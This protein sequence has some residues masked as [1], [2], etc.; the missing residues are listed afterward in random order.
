[1]SND[2]VRPQSE[3][4]VIPLR[5]GARAQRSEPAN[6]AAEA[7]EDYRTIFQSR[8]TSEIG[9]REVIS[10]KAKFGIFGDGKELPQVALARYIEPGDWRHGYYRDQ[11]LMLALRRV[12]VRQLFAQLYADTNIDHDPASGGRQMS[13]HFATRFLDAAGRFTDQLD[14]VNSAP[15]FGPIAFQMAS[16]L[17]LAYA[18]KLYRGNPGLAGV[19]AGFSRG[20]REVVFAS[21]GNASTSEGIF[22]ESI[23][24]AA[25]VQ[26]PMVV[27]VWDDGY[28]ISVPN[29]L[30]TARG[31]ISA[32]LAGLAA[33]G[34]GHG[35]QVREVDGWDYTALRA[36][37]A[38]V[39]EI[40]RREHIP[41]L[42]HVSGLT[43]PFGHSTSG[44]HERYKSKDRLAWEREFDG[45]RQ[46]RDWVLGQGY[47][48]PAELDELER[49][50]RSFVETERAVAW[51]EYTGDIRR[52]RD[53]VL[54]VMR[55][56]DAELPQPRLDTSMSELSSS[57]E[58]N[59]RLISSV[60]R[61]AV[62]NLRAE[63]ADARR[64]LVRLSA[65]Y[66]KTQRRRYTS[67]LFSESEE[68][69][70]KVPVV[71][72]LYSPASATADGRM[73]LLKCFDENFARDPRIF[74]VGEDVGKLGDVNL[75]YEGLQA[76]YG[77]L[78]LTDTGIRE[79][80]IL[81]QGIGA[82]M[83]GLRPIVDIQY[84]DYFLFALEVAADD[85]ATLHYRTAG[86]QKAPVVI[87]TKGHRLLGITHTGSPMSL[88]LNSCRGIYLCV[89][90]DMTRAAGMY[91]TLLRGDNPGMVVEVLNG[92]RVKE[93]VPDNVGT[94]TLPL[95]V[96]EVLRTG[97]DV[98]VA[99]YG[100]C[101][102]IV[103]D[104]A[105]AVAGIGIDVEVIDVQ[106]LSPFDVR[107]LLRES[108]EKTGAVVFVDEDVPGGA[109]AF[110][111]HQVLQV[112]G[113]WPY[114]DA[115]PV[116]LTGA[117]NR[118]P[119]GTDGDYFIKPSREDVI[120]AVYAVMRE[121][122]PARFPSLEG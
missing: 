99:T 81:G 88:I 108:V 57:P 75:V 114:L 80:T 56:V 54:E 43:Q 3:T 10:G 51:D 84:L 50:E 70:L 77:D 104:A 16:A 119:F 1:M 58:L 97:A 41:A 78:R 24:A 68:S 110:M 118:T 32:A 85:L 9:R 39:V 20:G 37:Y 105:E 25:V 60:L 4:S 7:V 35:M 45:V 83:R 40:A 121:R 79:A 101:C 103:L 71:P 82:A 122:E 96:P 23:N 5:P 109:S 46:M 100:A 92:Y 107:H 69:P 115:M 27:S 61:R 19:A 18:S 17:G 76:K 87:R 44:S 52:E 48:N 22:F 62:I 73:V 28:G 90:R 21:I 117:E 63:D 29:E 31:S 64:D 36:T 2:R 91:N 106:T 59:R 53:E 66:E 67:F 13:A 8:V 49:D 95:G 11:T 102:S 113:A 98:T 33:Q 86:G 26:V 74:V 65:N 55:A 89:P 12:T 6:L 120:E 116:T 112:Q 15:G 34:D 14:A 94:F 30:Q 72:P 93:K 47:S 42:V 38:E 111:Q